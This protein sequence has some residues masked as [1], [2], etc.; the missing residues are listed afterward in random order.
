[1]LVMPSI[2]GAHGMQAITLH[3]ID[4][5]RCG[6]NHGG[7]FIHPIK[8]ST[9]SFLSSLTSPSF[10]RAAV[11]FDAATGVLLAA[12]HLA[13]TEALAQWLG[14]PQG[15]LQASGLA[16]IGYAVLAGAIASQR[17]MPRGLLA[18][19]AAGNAAWALGSLALLLVSP[20][21][22]TAWGQAYLV[23]HIVSVGLLAEVQWFG[24]RHLPPMAMA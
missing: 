24:M 11:W 14:L 5:V 9:M 2:L 4:A 8:E 1:M 17:S 3:V 6:G 7:S 21:V 13:L 22:P 12:L 16:L 19:L 15:L 10:L 23:V 20:V 18:C